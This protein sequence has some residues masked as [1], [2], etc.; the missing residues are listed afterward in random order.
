MTIKRVQKVA[1][2][3]GIY[4]DGIKKWCNNAIGYAYEFFIPHGRG[5]YQ[6]ET[7][8]DAYKEIKEFPVLP[9]L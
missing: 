2:I 4:F 3:R 1:E 6:C 7:L 9:T 5:F 8:M